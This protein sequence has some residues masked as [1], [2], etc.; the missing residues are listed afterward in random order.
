MSLFL[1]V[2]SIHSYRSL[3]HVECDA[4]CRC[5][6]HCDTQAPLIEYVTAL[7]RHSH[8]TELRDKLSAVEAVAQ[9][10][11]R[12]IQQIQRYRLLSYFR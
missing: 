6:Q 1:T 3:I 4:F 12:E 9:I 2:L 11:K 5:K 7:N 10:L 8:L